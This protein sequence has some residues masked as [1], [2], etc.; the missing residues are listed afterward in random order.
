MSVAPRSN[1]KLSYKYFGP[2]LITQKVGAV[3]YKLQLPD[4]SKI[5]PVIHVSQLKKALPPS[6]EVSSNE[7]LLFIHTDAVL[8]HE[9]ILGTKLSHIGASTSPRVLVQWRGLPAQWATWESKAAIDAKMIALS[10]PA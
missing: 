9:K 8:V 5:H 3:A 2:Y 6:S 4:H 10:V 7:S 1:Q